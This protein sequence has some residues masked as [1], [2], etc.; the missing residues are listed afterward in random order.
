MLAYKDL[1]YNNFAWNFDFDHS[2]YVLTKETKEITD[3]V[4]FQP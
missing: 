1:F 3:F 4:L 2:M